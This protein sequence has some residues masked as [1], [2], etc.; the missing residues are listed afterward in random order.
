MRI[1]D[2]DGHLLPWN[3]MKWLFELSSEIPTIWRTLGW[4]DFGFVMK[5]LS[6]NWMD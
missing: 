2:E 1:R 3:W 4:L 5:Q 6:E